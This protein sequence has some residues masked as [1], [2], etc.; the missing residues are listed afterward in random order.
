MT[1]YQALITIIGMASCWGW[2]WVARENKYK[3]DKKRESEFDK[4]LFDLIATG[5]WYMKDGKRID[6]KDVYLEDM[7]SNYDEQG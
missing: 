7:G 6:P 3:R 4:A 5:A 1:V 2:G